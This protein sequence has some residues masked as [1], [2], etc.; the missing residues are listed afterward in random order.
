[1]RQVLK[2][3]QLLCLG[4]HIR[5][6]TPIQRH[7]HSRR[8]IGWAASNRMKR[9]LAIRALKMAIALRS[10]RTR[11]AVDRVGRGKEP[12]VNARFLAMRCPTGDCWQSPRGASHP[13]FEPEFC[14]PAA[15]WDAPA[16]RHRFETAG[17]GGPGD[18][19]V[20]ASRHR[21]WHAVTRKGFAC[22]SRKAMPDSPDLA[23]LNVW[24]ERRC[25]E[26]LHEIP[27]GGLPPP[28]ACKHALPMSG[29][30]NG[31]P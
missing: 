12:Q 2:G 3:G 8:V 11:T 15:G 23:A 26:L 18:R 29:P 5:K 30:K 9:D 19:S 1:M 28:H 4:L 21:L 16:C 20:Q 31:Q 10:G 7:G 17:E 6:V 22:K 13:G 24:L 27:D 25:Q 14:N